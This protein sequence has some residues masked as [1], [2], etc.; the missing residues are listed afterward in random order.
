MTEPAATTA[1][2]GATE[3]ARSFVDARQQAR[4]LPGFPGPLPRSLD[5]GY[6]IQEAAI[7]LWPA[8]VVG[9]KIGKVPP[10]VQAEVGETRLVGP[11]FAGNVQRPAAGEPGVFATIPGG[12]SAVEAEVVI[13]LAKDAPP[14]KL[15][16]TPEEA[17]DL[18]DAFLIGC[19]AAGSPLATINELGPRVVVSD[20]GNNAGLILGPAIPG[21]RDADPS[22]LTCRTL[23][24]GVEVGTGSAA[25][26]EGGPAGCLAWIL[27]H[28][29]R[30]GRPLRA[31]DLVTTGQLTGI[32][33]VRPGDE[34]I[35]D[36]GALGQV[37]CTATIAQAK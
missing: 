20:F 30:R 8:K 23:V 9:W 33:D 7:G 18:V 27:G 28:T 4:A 26:L 15:D 25:N 10:A 2:E 6:R 36:F 12:F 37:R 16:W 13:R 34:A 17:L 22:A 24:N 3:I 1:R 5:E 35:I 19:E 14:D 31:G 32:H 29:A 11:I 21:W